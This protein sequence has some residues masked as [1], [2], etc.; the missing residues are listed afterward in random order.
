MEPCLADYNPDSNSFAF[1]RTERIKEK[2]GFVC[3]CMHC[4]QAR[5]RV[6]NWNS[7]FS[8]TRGEARVEEWSGRASTAMDWYGVG[9]GVSFS[10]V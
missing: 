6:H 7:R 10:V 5:P 4:S 9:I 8:A 2:S 1:T 3:K